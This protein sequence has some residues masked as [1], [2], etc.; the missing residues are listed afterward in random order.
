MPKSTRRKTQPHGHLF[1][2]GGA[3]DRENDKLVLSRFV[4]LAGG[5]DAHIAVLTAAS[6][7]HDEVWEVYREAFRDLGVK[8]RAPV[9]IET[10]ERGQRRRAGAGHLR[11]RRGVH[12]RRRPGRSCCR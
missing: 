11:R 10:R 1:I 9:V 8:Q 4:D 12:D 3:E 2:I 5:K 6:N 7:Y